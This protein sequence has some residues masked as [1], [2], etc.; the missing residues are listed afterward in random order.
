M[1][2]VALFPVLD[3]LQEK[4]KAETLYWMWL[5]KPAWSAGCPD[6]DPCSEETVPAEGH[7]LHDVDTCWEGQVTGQYKQVTTELTFSWHE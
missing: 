1:S 5:Q 2:L 7:P 3:A 4:G 6:T